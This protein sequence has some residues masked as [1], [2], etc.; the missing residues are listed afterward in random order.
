M[1]L[2]KNVLQQIT[3]VKNNT[4]LHFFFDIISPFLQI[5]KNRSVSYFFV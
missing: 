4:F 2:E 3:E 5:E 1:V